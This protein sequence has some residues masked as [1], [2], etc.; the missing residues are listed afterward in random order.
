MEA[1]HIAF[2]VIDDGNEAMLADGHLVAEDAPPTLP[3]TGCFYTAIV[4]VEI[5]HR[6]A[7]T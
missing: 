2:G 3:G 1:D 4:A 7:G 5:H 6:P